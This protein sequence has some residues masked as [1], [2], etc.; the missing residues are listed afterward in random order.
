MKDIWENIWISFSFLALFLG[1]IF[2]LRYMINDTVHLSQSNSLK[3]YVNDLKKTANKMKTYKE[4]LNGCYAQHEKRSC[5]Y[6]EKNILELKAQYNVTVMKYNKL[7]KDVDWDN[8]N[9]IKG[10]PRT[11]S[12]MAK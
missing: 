1:V 11:Y 10:L 3:A 9:H 7:S 5:V 8:L 6:I 2:L 12:R 4:G